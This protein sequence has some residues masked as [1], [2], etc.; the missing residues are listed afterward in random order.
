MTGMDTRFETY[1]QMVCHY[2][3]HAT[4][5]EKQ[6][7]QTELAAHMEDHAQAL[8]DAGYDEAHAVSAALEAMGDPEEVGKA[9]NKE[10][11]LRWL[12]LSRIPAVLLIWIV[13]ALLLI[14][15]TFSRV[16]D[17]LEARFSPLSCVSQPGQTVELPDIR[18]E[19]PGG[20]VLVFCR[21]GVTHSD[22]DYTVY[23]SAVTYNKNPF[24]E[25]LNLWNGYWDFSLDGLHRNCSWNDGTF[26]L[27]E[28]SRGDQI[29]FHYNRY[30]AVFDLDIPLDWEEVPE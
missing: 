19:L 18:Q 20:N 10:Y 21:V 2:I 12:V 15:P 26:T 29:T 16:Q 1:G 24:Y 9:L 28:V 3:R 17:N 5:R 22:G 8:M 14:S 13:L 6:E 11:P 25:P 23:V 30:G 4:G 7:I 27:W